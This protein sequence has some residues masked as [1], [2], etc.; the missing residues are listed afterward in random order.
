MLLPDIENNL[1]A[2]NI[3]SGRERDIVSISDGEEDRGNTN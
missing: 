2:V 3:Q 1:L